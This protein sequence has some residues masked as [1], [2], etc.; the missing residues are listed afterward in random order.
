MRS[1]LCRRVTC[2]LTSLLR[3]TG[4]SSARESPTGEQV[5]RGAQRTLRWLPD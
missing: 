2:N 4:S 5:T 3:A 1:V